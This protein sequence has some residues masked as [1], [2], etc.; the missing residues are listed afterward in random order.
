MLNRIGIPMFAV[1]VLLLLIGPSQA[2]ARTHWS[3]GVSVGAPGYYYYPYYAPAYVYSAPYPYYDY[4]YPSYR[5]TYVY[6][7]YRYRYYTTYWGGGW[8]RHHHRYAYS[9]YY[10]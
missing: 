3:F 5:Y 10:R 2:S 1:L 9:Y 6:P 7:R 4:Y 8:R